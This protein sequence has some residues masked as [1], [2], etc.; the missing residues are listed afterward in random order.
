MSDPFEILG[1]KPGASILAVEQ[2]YKRLKEL[3]SEDS[4]ATYSL[5]DPE[6]RR[7][8]LDLMDQAFCQIVALIAER[9]K[10]TIDSPRVV[11][12]SNSENTPMPEPKQHPG[13]CLRW[14][15]QRAGLSLKD[16]SE[17]IK[18][19]STRLEDIELERF[20]SL[21]APVYL[22]GYIAEYVRYLNID[23]SKQLIENYLKQIPKK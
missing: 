20:D 8:R 14:F 23:E 7:E 16:L 12:G 3:Y 1:I 9:R 5:L 22:R 17:R 13:A 6:Q 18:I 21:P 2:A 15:R 10:I 11:A 19:S 4:L